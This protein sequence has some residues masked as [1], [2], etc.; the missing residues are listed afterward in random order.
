MKPTVK[1]KWYRNEVSLY[2]DEDYWA[3]NTYPVDE[4]SFE[5]A[6]VYYRVS[7]A[8]STCR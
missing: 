4:I 8:G 7:L 5:S 1:G 3:E 6:G 2:Y